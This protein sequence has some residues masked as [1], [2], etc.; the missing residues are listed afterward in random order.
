MYVIADIEWVDMGKHKLCPTQLAAI[1]VNPNWS[2]E[3]EAYARMRPLEGVE[4]PHI[5]FTGGSRQEFQ[6]ARTAF[7]ELSDFQTWL[8]S[9]DVICWWNSDSNETFHTVNK[10]IL[11]K[12]D[13]HVSVI[14]SDHVAGFLQHEKTYRGNAYRLAKARKIQTTE[15]QH[16]SWDDAEMIRILLEKIGFPQSYLAEPPIPV[17]DSETKPRKKAF[18]REMV[19][20]LQ[21]VQATYF[22]DFTDRIVHFMNC[23]EINESHDIK[24]KISLRKL[25]RKGFEPCSCCKDAFYKDLKQYNENRIHD[26]RFNYVFHPDSAV[27]HKPSC[28]FV[29]RLRELSG[30]TTYRKIVASGRR[31]CKFCNPGQADE[32]LTFNKAPGEEQQKREVVRACAR[33]KQAQKER[34]SRSADSFQTEQERQDFMTLTQPGY[35]FWAVRGYQS[36][37]RRDCSKLKGMS[38]ILGYARYSDAMHSGFRPCKCCKPSPKQDMT[39]SIPI[40]NQVRT[41][42]STQLLVDLCN[43]YGYSCAISKLDFEMETPAGRWKIALDKNPITMLH[44]NKFKGSQTNY[45]RQPRLFLSLQD[46]FF[47][48]HRHDKNLMEQ[49]MPLEEECLA[50]AI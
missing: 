14:L 26:A 2:V 39:Y 15:V 49:M 41:G 4:W 10:V 47:Y 31:P 17:I 7:E 20:A 27:Y 29:S 21:P 43:E 28:H 5:A 16:H 42:E 50:G 8:R 18:S 6:Q 48:I 44:I 37:H 34:N 13:E 22:V 45:H 40:T 46:A 32:L 30:V 1:R 24:E 3:D 36:F 9:D 38:H 25:F 11:G 19:T 33:L 35:V 23:S 12:D